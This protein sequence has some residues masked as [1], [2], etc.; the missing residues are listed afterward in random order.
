MIENLLY[1]E[2]LSLLNLLKQKEQNKRY[3]LI[4][5]YFPEK[6]PLSRELYYK[7]ME[8]FKAGID[9]KFRLYMA[10]NRIGKTLCAGYEL[11][12][13]LTGQ[14]PDWWPGKR[15]RYSNNWWVCGVNSKL[16]RSELQTLL[17]GNVG[18]FGTGLIPYEYLDIDSLK[19]AK[20]AETSIT[21]FRVKHISGTY[22]SVQFKSYESGREAFQSAKVNIW[23]DEECSLQIFLECLLRTMDTGP[24]D[25]LSL[26]FTFTPLKG[27]TDMVLN[28]LEY[29]TMCEGVI[30]DKETNTPTPKYVVRCGWD[31]V[32]HLSEIEKTTL[33][34]AI[35]P[36]ARDARTKGIPQMGSG[37][38]Y[39][40]PWSQISVPRFEI[41]KHW[42]RYGGMDVGTK[43]A[44]IW[45]AIDPSTDV[46]YAYYEYYREGALPSVHVQGMSGPGLWIP[47]AIDHAA[48]GR[49]QI[50]G[51][52]LFKIYEDLGLKLHNADKAVEAGLYTCWE[53]L[54]G[55]KVKIFED[56]KMFR[57]EYLVYMKDE[58]GNV[59]KK[60]DHI[61]DA[62]RYAQMTGVNLATNLQNIK[63]VIQSTVSRQYIPPR[64]GFKR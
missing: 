62:F 63:P 57:E 3:R 43:T 11:T 15:Y 52:N 13:H 29:N 49:S 39:C 34:K 17:L 1:E 33:L 45:F 38:I 50:D 27:P 18:E 42:K 28:F 25:P 12:C 31:D 26:M 40:V 44:A 58:K 19:E 56:L 14:Y 41:P 16:V 7:V 46:H 53:R 55:G 51:E 21:T 10:A 47:I 60:N 59:V 54:E 35:P 61:M 48:R 32:P 2:K 5:K 6:G 36:W 23:L 64:Q 22:S 8:F 4:D 24:G 30:I 9:Y 20:S 37:I